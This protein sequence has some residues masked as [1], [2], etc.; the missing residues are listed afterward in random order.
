[1]ED[2]VLRLEQWRKIRGLSQEELAKEVGISSKSIWNYESNIENLRGASYDTVHKIA[3]SL[4]IRT[5]QIFLE[6]TS[7]KPNKR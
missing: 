3:Q 4:G 1:M 2:L 7:E 6:N 5:N